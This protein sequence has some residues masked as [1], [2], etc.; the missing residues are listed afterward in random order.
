MANEGTPMPYS[1]RISAVAETF[2]SN[3]SV[4]IDAA[5]ATV[6]TLSPILLMPESQNSGDPTIPR[7][8][9]GI[10]LGAAGLL[11]RTTF[12][13]HRDG[14]RREQTALGDLGS[15]RTSDP[16]TVIGYLGD[17]LRT[18]QVQQHTKGEGQVDSID[19]LK[20]SQRR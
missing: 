1:T 6:G 10:L 4:Q 18:G 7:F 13:Q 2:V 19:K 3:R 17:A 12:N 9:V 11:T 5:L 15:Y 20:S 8:L 14:K 16:R